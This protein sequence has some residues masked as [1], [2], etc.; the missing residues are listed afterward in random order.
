MAEQL[1]GGAHVAAR[2]RAVADLQDG[3]TIV[4]MLEVALEPVDQDLAHGRSLLRARQQISRRAG[5]LGCGNAR[6]LPGVTLANA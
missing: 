2:S 5:H 6:A 3:V 4:R 1:E